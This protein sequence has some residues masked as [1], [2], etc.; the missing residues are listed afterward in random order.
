MSLYNFIL[1]NFAYTFKYYHDYRQ[2]NK[3]EAVSAF[4]IRLEP[5]LYQ[6]ELV[7]LDGKLL[8]QKLIDFDEKCENNK[9]TYFETY[10]T[11]PK[12]CER[13]F[14]TPE[15]RTKFFDIR[16]KTI[17]EIQQC[18]LNMIKVCVKDHYFHLRCLVFQIVMI[19]G[20]SN[21][22]ILVHDSLQLFC[23]QLFKYIPLL[24]I[25]SSN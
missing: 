18:I 19:N 1:S 5:Y 9:Q 21:Y 14:V 6:Q 15:D 12:V 13:V 2:F 22:L 3:D 24:Q 16:N 20:N 23:C 10:P 8:D 25:N 17:S 7:T 4:E 11:N